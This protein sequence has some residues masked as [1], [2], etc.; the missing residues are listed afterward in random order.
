MIIQDLTAVANSI[1]HAEDA[2][3][4]AV[5]NRQHGML[6]SCI[7]EEQALL[8]KLR[9]LEQHR[10]KLQKELGWDTLTLHQILDVASPL[11]VQALDPVFQKLDQQLRR[12]QTAREA[13]EQILNVRLHELKVFSEMGASYDNGG[14]ATPGNIPQG[15]GMIR[16]TYV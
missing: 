11:Q 10:I 2:K 7:Q 4:A 5:S 8:L 9:G 16:N 3:T 15:N 6:D 1:T 14:N 12:L 13:S